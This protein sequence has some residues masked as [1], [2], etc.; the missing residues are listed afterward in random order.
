LPLKEL[1]V[2]TEFQIFECEG[3]LVLETLMP[4]AQWEQLLT[5]TGIFEADPSVVLCSKELSATIGGVKAGGPECDS[6]TSERDSGSGSSTL[7]GE[8]VG[9]RVGLGVR[10]AGDGTRGGWM[11]WASASTSDPEAEGVVKTAGD[12]VDI[13]SSMLDT[14]REALE[15]DQ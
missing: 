1:L 7:C 10:S 14:G 3:V 11:V 9:C 4:S 5:S 12:G 15:I 8:G 6:E 13:I 2:T